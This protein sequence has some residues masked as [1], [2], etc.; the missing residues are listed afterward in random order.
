MKKDIDLDKIWSRVGLQELRSALRKIE[1][2]SAQFEKTLSDLPV[3]DQCAHLRLLE[4]IQKKGKDLGGEVISLV[5]LA[6]SLKNAVVIAEK[7][8]EKLVEQCPE[9]CQCHEDQC[10]CH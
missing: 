6:E 2:L 9:T 3:C 4:E 1:D 7:T 8:Q 10:T 5:S